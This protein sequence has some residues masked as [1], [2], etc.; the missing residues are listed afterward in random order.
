MTPSFVSL[1]VDYFESLPIHITC[2][3]SGDF[4]PMEL[5]AGGVQV[6]YMRVYDYDFFLAFRI[7]HTNML[8]AA[9]RLLGAR[10]V[11]ANYSRSNEQMRA[12]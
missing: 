1:D 6:L 11:L 5:I 2:N 3:D 4:L 9:V 10:I 7:T 8:S 12:I